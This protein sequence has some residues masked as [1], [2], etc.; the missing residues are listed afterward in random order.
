M[1]CSKFTQQEMTRMDKPSHPQHLW[2]SQTRRRQTQNCVNNVSISIKFRNRERG[3]CCFKSGW[4]SLGGA[5][6]SNWESFSTWE[7][8]WALTN[9][10]KDL[11]R[12]ADAL[13]HF[14]FLLTIGS[15][16]AFHIDFW[17]SAVSSGLK[18]SFIQG[19]SSRSLFTF[20]QLSGSFFHTWP[21]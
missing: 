3:V 9:L 12:Q 19:S 18:W 8:L 10:Q 17:K 4:L 20:G 2:I 16:E 1:H 5:R 6:S 21:A 13:T 11:L 14:Y 15:M 7:V